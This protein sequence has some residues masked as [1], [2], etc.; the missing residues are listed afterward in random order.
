VY[1][2][3]L[4]VKN[5]RIMALECLQAGPSSTTVSPPQDSVVGMGVEG[6]GNAREASHEH[7]AERVRGVA[8]ALDCAKLQEAC[9]QARSER[10]RVVAETEAMR[11][12]Y[13][14]ASRILIK[15]NSKIKDKEHGLA[16]LQQVPGPS[17]APSVTCDP[18]S[19]G[20]IQ[21]GTPLQQLQ[22]AQAKAPQGLCSLVQ[23]GRTVEGGDGVVRVLRASLAQ[24]EAAR[25]ESEQ[26]LSESEARREEA[27]R[28]VA[29]AR[30]L[31]RHLSLSHKLL[32]EHQAGTTAQLDEATVRAEEQQRQ[33]VAAREVRLV[34][35]CRVASHEWCCAALRRIATDW[36]LLR[37]HMHAD[38]E[39]PFLLSRSH[40]TGGR[41]RQRTGWS[42][43]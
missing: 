3:M 21:T 24:A 30:A 37:E 7:A 13:E 16:S 9:E 39:I 6:T 1:K 32:A 18:A 12:Q 27:C 42:S 38:Y 34:N 25:Q 17:G 20:A 23:E 4:Q 14:S 36:S 11:Q 31:H 40:F 19:P 10:A 35:I 2:T 15:L 33:L 26:A 43:A 29:E 22:Q 28:E 5:Q 8:M 41:R